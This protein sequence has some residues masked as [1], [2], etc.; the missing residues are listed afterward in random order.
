M[1]QPGRRQKTPS[2]G[3]PRGAR[4]RQPPGEFRFF[5]AVPARPSAPSARSPPPPRR[6]LFPGMARS[7]RERERVIPAPLPFSLFLT[8][9]LQSLPFLVIPNPRRRPSS[10]SSGARPG[11]QC[12]ARGARSRGE[13]YPTTRSPPPASPLAGPRPGRRTARPR[14]RARWL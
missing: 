11:G 3:S 4:L 14:S 10:L 7:A 2:R 5:P 8:H 13:R 12:E 6:P 1:P 9:S